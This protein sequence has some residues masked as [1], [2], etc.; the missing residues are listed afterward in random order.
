MLVQPYYY[1]LFKILGVTVTSFIGIVSLLLIVS[2]PFLSQWVA[3]RKAD[4]RKPAQR[5]I[6]V[7][8]LALFTVGFYS[9]EYEFDERPELFSDLI[10][11]DESSDCGTEW[12]FWIGGAKGLENPCP[13][14]CYRG[15]TVTKKLR[16]RGIF[17]PWPQTRREMQCWQ[18]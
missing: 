17:P 11:A 1:Y 9:S 15:V 4:L 13:L 10:P 18:R 6:V 8:G 14:N 7:A 12:T 5:T 3:T 16:M 2:A